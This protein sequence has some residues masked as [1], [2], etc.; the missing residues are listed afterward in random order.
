MKWLQNLLFNSIA[1]F[2]AAYILSGVAVNNFLT[3]VGVAL[4]LGLINT[5]LK[6]ILIFFTLPINILTFGLFTL[7]I[8]A[9]LVLL[10][11]SLI[12]GFIVVGLWPA[13]WFSILVSTINWLLNKI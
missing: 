1:V 3:A 7:I 6:P 5:F 9:S 8:N 4:V 10:A 13:L 12:D 2:L 11:S